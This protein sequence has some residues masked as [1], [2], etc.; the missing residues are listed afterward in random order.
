MDEDESRLVLKNLSEA[1]LM[2]WR[3]DLSTRPAVVEESFR[4]SQHGEAIVRVYRAKKGSILL[5]A[6]GGAVRLAMMRSTPT[7]Q[8]WLQGEVRS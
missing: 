7:S 2:G 6:Q 1:T 4:D 8:V 3:T 5:K